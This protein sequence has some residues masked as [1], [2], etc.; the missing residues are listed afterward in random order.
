MDAPRG[1]IRRKKSPGGGQ[2]PDSSGR[3]VSSQTGS[4]STELVKND[5]RRVPYTASVP[6]VEIGALMARK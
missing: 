4:D 6:M 5:R 3:G 2:F 1:I